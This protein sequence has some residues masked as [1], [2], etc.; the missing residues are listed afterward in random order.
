MKTTSIWFIVAVTLTTIFLFS[1]CGFS[2]VV[3]TSKEKNGTHCNQ[4]LQDQYKK[5]NLRQI[6]QQRVI[7]D[8]FKGLLK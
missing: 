1:A 8:E 3:L 2:I 5:E 4:S 7:A 6:E